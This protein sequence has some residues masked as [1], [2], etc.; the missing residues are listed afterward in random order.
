MWNKSTWEGELVIWR[1]GRRAGMDVGPDTV[2]EVVADA[3]EMVEHRV[4]KTPGGTFDCESYG[5]VRIT[6]ER[7]EDG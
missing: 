4:E 2:R 6:I 7:L 1:Q 5:N 3:F